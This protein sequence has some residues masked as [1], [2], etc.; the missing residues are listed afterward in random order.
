MRELLL[1][2]FIGALAASLFWMWHEKNVEACAFAQGIAAIH[3]GI[4]NEDG[5]PYYGAYSFSK[6]DYDACEKVG[7]VLD[8]G[9][10]G[11]R[12]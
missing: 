4:I 10:K 9:V 2:L 12:R 3:R 6:G 7:E 5:T 11:E 8:V 1:C